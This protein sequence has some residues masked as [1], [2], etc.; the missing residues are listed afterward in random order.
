MLS[1]DDENQPL[2]KVAHSISDH[3]KGTNGSSSSS[4]GGHKDAVKK[5]P[6]KEIKKES[7]HHSS[8]NNSSSEVKK[9]GSSSSSKD[10]VKVK[11]EPNNHH[12][13]K[14]SQSFTESNGK[15][16]SSDVKKT[17]PTSMSTSNVK[18]EK[19]SKDDKKNGSSKNGVSSSK[20]VNGSSSSSKSTPKQET[21]AI[22][23]E[24]KVKQESKTPVKQESKKSSSKTPT[25]SSK[26][27]SKDSKKRAADE[28]LNNGSPK[29]KKKK[30]EEEEE[31]W[32]WWEE[33][34]Y[35]DG[36]KWTKLEH[37]GPVFEEGYTP[38]PSSIQFF[39]NGEPMKLCV[40][41]EEVM[42][43]YAKMLDHDYTKKEVFNTNFFNDWRKFM[44]ES[45][46]AKIK[47]LKKCD[48]SKVFDYYKQKSEE[49][50]A[51]SKEEKKKLAEANNAIKKEFGFCVWDGHKQPIGN[52][53]IEPPGLFRG[54]GEH[55]KMGMVKR[56]T[57]PEDVIINCGKDSK[58]PQAPAGHKW[59]EV[60][61]DNMVAWLASW[62][63]NVQGNTKY[64]MLNASSRVKGERDWQKYEKARKLHR[65]IDQ[66]RK[67]YIEDWKSKEM[68]V[69]QR[70]VAIYFIDKLAL[71][72][73]NEKD[74]DEADTV[75]CC[76]LRVE[77]IKLHKQCE[78]L[79]E[80]VVEFDFLG[81]DSIR[82]QNKVQVEKQVFKNLVLFVENKNGEDELF[83]RLNTTILNT[84][85]NEI[86]EG[87]SAKVFRTY[88][89]SRT[90]QEQL[91]QMTDSKDHLNNKILSYNRANRAVAILCNHQRAVPKTFAKS[92]ENMQTKI[93]EK[94]TQITEAE[95]ELKKA[96]SDLKNLKTVAAKKKYETKEKV[97]EK[98][99][100][101][102]K[103]LEIQVTD[104]DEN[105]DIA[106]GTSKLNYLDPRISVAWSK[107][108]NVPIE[109]IYSKTQREK[110]RW[111]I[112]MAT[113][114][115]HF[116]NYEGEIQ[117]RDTSELDEMEGGNTTQD[118]QDDTHDG[119]EEE[120][121]ED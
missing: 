74:E 118:T 85:L 44:S 28:S 52:Y 15:K 105:K 22:K 68:K 38:L 75:G 106:L 26:S 109:K 11:S 4:S 27:S 82:Y 113:A 65:Y 16:S 86:M 30:E 31:V 77:H 51:L 14:H 111:A 66:L 21:K 36:R 50:K 84:Y 64:V 9:N 54:R 114:E 95:K 79:G 62:T 8:H 116:Y 6:T 13:D 42:G 25:S 69:R 55:P 32:R 35:A 58:V 100:E 20:Q 97:L 12:H 107:K 94:K 80:N 10:A 37:K 56:R 40:G 63:E 104:K 83:D 96:K 46:R 57:Q 88:N 1:S 81:K 115:Y 108:H 91:D 92:M 78:G 87:L 61:H 23:S 110:F 34:K 24:S 3:S 59:K 53:K 17:L 70:A 43:F 90:L 71:R 39:Y 72:A 117:L 98:L 47:D 33:K 41:A 2:S 5:E 67:N 101:G 60:R 89:A 18:S 112:D 93:Q 29:K 7:H 48:F 73:G 49:R 19:H 103:K 102:L 119:D 45:E 121:D 76:S 99:R 120:E